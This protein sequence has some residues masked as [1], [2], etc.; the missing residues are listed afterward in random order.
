MQCSQIQELMFYKFKLGHNTVKATK[1]IS[2][3]KGED[4]VDSS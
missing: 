2:C 4:A 3:A 1:I